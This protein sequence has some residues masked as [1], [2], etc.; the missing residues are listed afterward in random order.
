M[1]VRIGPGSLNKGVFVKLNRDGPG[2]GE[3]Y[4]VSNPQANV[5]GLLKGTFYGTISD[6]ISVTCRGGDATERYRA[7]IEYKDESWISKPR[8]LLEGVVYKYKTGDVAAELRKDQGRAIS[9]GGRYA[10]GMLADKDQ[11]EA[12]GR[13]GPS[14][15]SSAPSRRLSQEC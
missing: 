9:G 3:E 10:R 11:L 6:Q 8:F 12:Q 5:N 13:E 4:Q 15:R 14:C 2:K 7:I 1:S